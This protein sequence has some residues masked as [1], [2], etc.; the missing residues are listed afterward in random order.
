MA[1][2]RAEP[3]VGCV[4]ESARLAGLVRRWPAGT[5]VGSLPQHRSGAEASLV[6]LVR[7]LVSRRCI[8]GL[9][10]RRPVGIPAPI[11]APAQAVPLLRAGVARSWS[12]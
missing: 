8:A 2:Q 1:G 10:E 4:A 5:P 3:V 7:W 11:A 9:V 6:V 12:R